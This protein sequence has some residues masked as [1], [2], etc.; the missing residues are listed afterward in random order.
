MTHLLSQFS[1]CPVCGSSDFR[2]NDFKSKRC[3]A[4]GFTYYLNSA[5]A[6]AAVIFNA[7]GE[8]LVA[9]RAEEPEKGM[10]DF[11]GGFADAGETLEQGMLREVMEE[12][13]AEVEIE[14]FLFSLPNIYVYSGFPVHTLDCFFLCRL[15]EGANIRPMDDVAELLWVSLPD[16]CVEDFG[17]GS[18][19]QGIERIIELKKQAE[20]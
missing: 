3:D 6:S 12:T 13:G 10:L 2:V 20:D 7:A 5:A 19:R 14:R 1:F 9:R 4:C 11:P 15:K 18:A 16:V 17:V 8:L